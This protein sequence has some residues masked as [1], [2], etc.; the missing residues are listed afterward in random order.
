MSVIWS[1][2]DKIRIDNFRKTVPINVMLAFIDGATPAQKV[3]LKSVV[4]AK[5]VQ[6]QAALDGLEAQKLASETGLQLQ[7]DDLNA[8]KTQIDNL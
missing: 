2:A 6:V 4:D 5:I 1:E 8:F 3:I 7:L